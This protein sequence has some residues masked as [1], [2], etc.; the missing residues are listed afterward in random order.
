VVLI[1]ESNHHRGPGGQENLNHSSKK[2]H[3]GVSQES[4][5]NNDL[6]KTH[7]YIG[8]TSHYSNQPNQR[9]QRPEANLHPENH[10]AK[11]N[12][13][14]R[15]LDRI[16]SIANQSQKNLSPQPNRSKSSTSLR[17]SPR[18]EQQTSKEQQ[19]QAKPTNNATNYY[20]PP[21]KQVFHPKRK[22]PTHLKQVKPIEEE[23]E[24]NNEF[25]T[26]DLPQA[27][28]GIWPM[29]INRPNEDIDVT[30]KAAEY[31]YHSVTAAESTESDLANLGIGFI[32]LKFMDSVYICPTKNV[33]QCKYFQT[34]I[35]V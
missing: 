10:S 13:I 26:A 30:Q 7:H 21:E 9:T 27:P 23:E 4:D 29:P 2:R 32:K 3:S 14:K 5:H 12:E 25:E 20:H 6:A 1:E 35:A 11:S 22:S 17:I 8:P 19:P 16:N 15:E 18:K 24:A 31:H 33:P 28:S 34:S